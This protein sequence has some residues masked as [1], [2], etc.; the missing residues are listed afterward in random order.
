MCTFHDD[1]PRRLKAHAI[2]VARRVARNASRRERERKPLSCQRFSPR[3]PQY[4]IV[5]M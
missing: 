5:L 4:D 2:Q 3:P 1:P